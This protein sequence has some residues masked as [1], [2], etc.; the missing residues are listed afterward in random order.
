MF[1]A[2]SSADMFSPQF[3]HVSLF[4]ISS[5]VPTPTIIASFSSLADSL[6][7]AGIKNLPCLSI[8]HSVAPDRKNLTKFLAFLS[9]SGK[10]LS[11]VSKLFH[12]FCENTNKHPSKPF[13]IINFSPMSCLNFLLLLLY[14]L[15]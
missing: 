5:L 15:P 2:I 4:Q 11:F 14:R 9:D 3:S 1:S 6:K 10:V 13:V 7:F 8:S 12:S